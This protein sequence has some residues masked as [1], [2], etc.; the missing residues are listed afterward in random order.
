MIALILAA[1]LGIIIGVIISARASLIADANAAERGWVV[2][3]GKI[4]TLTAWEAER[5][6]K[7]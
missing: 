6:N 2:I 5:E 7:T 4:Y 3:S 1:L